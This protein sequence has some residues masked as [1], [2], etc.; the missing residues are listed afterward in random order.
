MT[1]V[2]VDTH[3]HLSAAMTQKQLLDFIVDKVR[4]HSDDIVGT[5][6]G[7]EKTLGQIFEELHL[8]A[9]TLT[10]DRLDTKGD[11]VM[12][13]FDKF[14]SKYNPFGIGSLRT[15]FLKSSNYIKGR[16]YA[17][18]T[19]KLFDGM[20]K[21]GWEKSEYR[22]SIYG[23]SPSE[24][25]KL[26]DWVYENKLFSKDNRFMIQVPRIYQ[27]FK[28]NGQINSFHEMLSNIFLPL[29]QASIEP[30]KYPK[31]NSFLQQVSGFDSV[32]DESKLEPGFSSD[33]PSPKNWTSNENPPYVTNES[34][35]NEVV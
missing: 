4:N 33:L 14:N 7:E 12:Q 8:T 16:Y 31:L 2:R 9:D 25:E 18:L 11:N 10:V 21:K 5:E 6:K 34:E 22:I 3:I 1:I 17:E 19:Q 30:E 20:E 29:F 15:I 28:K 35:T 32:D 27:V 13:R 24:W 23:R 26:S